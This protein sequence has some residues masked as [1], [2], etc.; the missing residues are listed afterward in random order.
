MSTSKAGAWTADLPAAPTTTNTPESGEAG[1]P[2]RTVLALVSDILQNDGEAGTSL[3]ISGN[4]KAEQHDASE[5]EGDDGDEDYV[6]PAV[7]GPRRGSKHLAV[8]ARDLFCASV[9]AFLQRVAGEATL[10]CDAE[11]RR[12]MTPEHLFLALERVGYGDYAQ[13]LRP[14]A[15]SVKHEQQERY[16]KKNV[17]A[18]FEHTGLSMEELKRQQAELLAAARDQPLQL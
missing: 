2:K 13:R 7:T 5:D 16:R 3:A 14:L 12:T 4:A 15:E 8:E 10:A 1:L 6:A 11:R 18:R 17:R 9:N